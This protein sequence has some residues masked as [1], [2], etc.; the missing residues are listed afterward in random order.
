MHDLIFKE[1]AFRIIGACFEVYNE[2]GK[3]YNEV[4]Y[5][6]AL[7]IEFKVQKIPYSRESKFEIPYKGYILNRYYNADFVVF[8]KIILEVKAIEMLTISH[9]KQ[10]INYLAASKLK[11]GILANFGEDSLKYQRIVL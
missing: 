6:D 9:K 7:E 4:V 8:D 5:K 10:T 11:L 2:L 3:G 1:E